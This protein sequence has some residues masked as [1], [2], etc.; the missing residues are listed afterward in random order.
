LQKFIKILL[1]QNTVMQKKHLQHTDR[2]PCNRFTTLLKKIQSNSQKGRG[3]SLKRLQG[4]S[5]RNSSTGGTTA[6]W[7]DDDNDDD[8]W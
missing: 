2:M 8:V 3:R 4:V 6:C 1:W 7:P 5:D